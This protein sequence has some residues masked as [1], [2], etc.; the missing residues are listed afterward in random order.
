MAP[1]KSVTFYLRTPDG[2]PKLRRTTIAWPF[3]TFREGR[4]RQQDGYVS[5]TLKTIVFEGGFFETDDKEIIEFLDVYNSGGIWKRSDGSWEQFTIG[6]NFISNII[7]REKAKEA[8]KTVMNT[9]YVE[10]AMIPSIIVDTFSI[11]QLK[12]SCQQFGITV[13]KDT[14]QREAYV[15]LLK[16]AWHIQA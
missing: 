14:V 16:D 12:A 8:V 5:S 2:K 11:E 4:D 7:T 1:Q 9:E 10:K 6:A 3:G 15:A 13:P